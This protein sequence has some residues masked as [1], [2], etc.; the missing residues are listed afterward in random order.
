MIT[1]HQNRDYPVGNWAINFYFNIVIKA[2][3]LSRTSFGIEF[4]RE[5]GYYKSYLS[6]RV[7]DILWTIVPLW[8][9]L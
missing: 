4:Q 7:K 2:S 9:V 6:I 1:T 3:E 8:T 5:N